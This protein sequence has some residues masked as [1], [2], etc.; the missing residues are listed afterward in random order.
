MM[1]MRLSL[2]QTLFNHQPT[3]LLLQVAHPQLNKKKVMM[4]TKMNMMMMKKLKWHLVKNWQRL[5]MI[6]KMK[7]KSMMKIFI[8]N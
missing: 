7:D 6:K 1:K 3:I 8:Q 5:K 4:M 2:N